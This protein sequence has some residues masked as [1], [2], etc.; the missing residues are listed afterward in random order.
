MK[1]TPTRL[2]NMSE[3]VKKSQKNEQFY[4]EAKDS[5]ERDEWLDKPDENVKENL[6]PLLKTSFQ[7]WSKGIRDE[8]LELVEKRI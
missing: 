3:L 4:V 6:L 7:F 8:L 2:S 1:L 5:D